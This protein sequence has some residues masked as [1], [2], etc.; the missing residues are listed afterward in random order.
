MCIR[1]SAFV[2]GERLESKE[3]FVVAPAKTRLRSAE[4]FGNQP[5]VGA[6]V[7]QSLARM[8]HGVNHGGQQQAEDP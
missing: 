2:V 6:P 1:G 7:H 8:R 3:A 5:S 4:L